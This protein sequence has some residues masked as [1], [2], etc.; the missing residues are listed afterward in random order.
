MV[1]MYLNSHPLSAHMAEKTKTRIRQAVDRFKY[2]PSYLARALSNKKTNV[3]GFICGDIK[4]PFF[5]EK[6]AAM[7]KA[8][9]EAG[10]RL[11][12]MVTEWNFDK[13]FEC[14][15]F[16]LE[17]SADGIIFYNRGLPANSAYYKKIIEEK[18][19]VVLIAGRIKNISCVSADLEPGFDQAVG[20]LI[21][22]G[23]KRI[24]M[25]H[26]PENIIKYKTYCKICKKYKIRPEQIIYKDPYYTGKEPLISL[27]KKI[28]KDKYADAV[29]AA[30]DY[31]AA[32]LMQGIREAGFKIPDDISMVG[33]DGIELGE[34][35][36]PPLSTIGQ[37]Q[38]ELAAAAVSE[39]IKK[40]N[41][42]DAKSEN[43]IIPSFF[44]DRKSIKPRSHHVQLE[45]PKQ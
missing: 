7:M 28:A 42:P 22:S 18:L 6:A 32:L 40:I 13:E 27:G 12:I 26:D 43:L 16:L 41:N 17:G 11:Q 31:D 29:I 30:A 45:H 44:I 5:A 3:I 19:P 15:D 1:S 9:N 36:Y 8:A 23:H 21:T 14:F 24:V 39:L 10:Y 37:P 34:Y 25:A 20:K 33:M 35:F 38:N 2:K 4:S